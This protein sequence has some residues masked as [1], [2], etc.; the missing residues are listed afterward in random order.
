MK[1]VAVTGAE[2][3]TTLYTYDAQKRLETMA[4][5]GTSGGLPADSYSKF[6]RDG[7]GRIV[8]VKQKLADPPGATADTSIRNYHYPD[9][10]TLN[11]DYS[12]Q[13]STLDLGGLT[14]TTS[15]SAV[16]T[17]S[18]GKMSSYYSYMS[19]SLVPG[20]VMQESKTDFSYDASGKVTAVKIYNSGSIPGAPLSLVADYTYTYAPTAISG[21]YVSS[22][23]AQNFALAGLPNTTTAAVSKM[24]MVSNAT[25]PPLTVTITST[26]VT[27]GGNK[28]TSAKVVST[29]TG[30]PTQTINYTFF[31]Q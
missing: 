10:T 8:Q 25:T 30:Q 20:T 3:Q 9:G 19:S 6:I 5:S 18:S 12:L 23:G 21:V 27:G 2:T 26:F 24:L 14:M 7:A 17:Y 4:I 11:Y 29:T 1:A 13:T 28:V 31:Y 16:Y 22:S 15:D